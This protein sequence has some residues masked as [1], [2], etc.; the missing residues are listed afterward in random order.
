MPLLKRMQHIQKFQTQDPIL[1][2]RL[3]KYKTLE[4]HDGYSMFAFIAF[5]CASPSQFQ[6]IIMCYHQPI[7]RCPFVVFWCD[8]AMA[9]CRSYAAQPNA[10]PLYLFYETFANGT[11]AIAAPLLDERSGAGSNPLQQTYQPAKMVC[12]WWLNM[13]EY[14]NYPC[15]FKV[16]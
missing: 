11:R 8:C 5:L 10:A 4:L 15:C 16:I 6:F 1:A 7:P 2:D 9:G 3:V 13:F 12:L 14:C